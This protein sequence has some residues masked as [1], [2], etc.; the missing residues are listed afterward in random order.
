TWP[1]DEEVLLP[2]LGLARARVP[3]LRV[4]LA[5]HEPGEDRVGALLG[6]LMEDGWHPGTL[7]HVETDGSLGDM[8]AVVVER[9]GVL[10]ELYAVA[11]AAYV[12]VGCHDAGLHSVLE[13]AASGVPVLFGPRHHNTRAA[14]ALIERGAAEVAPNA[15]DAA[16]AL[17]R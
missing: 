4:V 12:G 5:P 11:T 9:V 1:S 2:A 16:E 14:A 6:A 10:A 13:P 17:L 3:G 15:A 7:R 8:D